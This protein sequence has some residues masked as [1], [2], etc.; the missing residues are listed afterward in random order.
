ME[1]DID[2]GNIQF[3]QNKLQYEGADSLKLWYDGL[4]DYIQEYVIDLLRLR[5]IELNDVAQ[6][7]QG[8]F[9]ESDSVLSK[10]ITR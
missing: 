2:P 5:A 1:K 6:T 4:E 7:L 9:T 3:I 8:T 10:F